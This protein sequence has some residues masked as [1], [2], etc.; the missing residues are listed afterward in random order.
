MLLDTLQ[1]VRRV[2]PGRR[3]CVWFCL[4]IA[5]YEVIPLLM[6][7]AVK[8]KNVGTGDTCN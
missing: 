3:L 2:N 4:L 6:Q 7:N 1:R 8:M 5:L